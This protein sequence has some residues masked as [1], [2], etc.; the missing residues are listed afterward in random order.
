[1]KNLTLVFVGDT[2]EITS[3]FFPPITLERNQN[4]HVGLLSLDTYNSIANIRKNV[5]NKFTVCG[6]V[7]KPFEIPAGGYEIIDI[8]QV[9]NVILANAY[10]RGDFE[11]GDKPAITILPNQ[12]TKRVKLFCNYSLD[13][14]HANSISDILGFEKITLAKN[15]T[16]I[17]TRSVDIAPYKTIAVECNIASGSYKNGVLTHDIFQFVPTTPPGYA[18]TEHPSNIIYYPLNTNIIDSVT[19]RLVDNAGNSIDFG[20]ENITIRL[21]IKTWV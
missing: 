3:V 5:N 10:D 17:G 18:I 12:V 16:H 19:V 9:M 14:S 8:E 21:N 4:Y 13:L 6:L 7:C 2:S 20:G 1:M 11:G 15:E